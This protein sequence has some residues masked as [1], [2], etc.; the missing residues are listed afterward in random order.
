MS[1][2]PGVT[3]RPPAS[4]VRAAEPS[5]SPTAAMIPS[6]IAMSACCGDAPVPSM[7]S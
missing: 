7:T 5:T 6:A 2:K 3:T 1:T 4:I